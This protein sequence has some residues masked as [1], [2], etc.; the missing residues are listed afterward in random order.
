ML[1]ICNGMARSGSTYQ[2][3]LAKLFI[4]GAGTGRAHAYIAPEAADTPLSVAD[5]RFARWVRS[6]V[7]HV[8]KTHRMH[9]LVPQMVTEGRVRLLYIHRDIRDVAVS[10]K[11]VWG[12][13]GDDLVQSLDKLIRVYEDVREIRELAPE[14]VLWQ[15]YGDLMDEPEAVA[16]E[17]RR[18]LGIRISEAD[19][20]DIVDECSLGAVKE[21]CGVVE[22]DLRRRVDQLRK[23]DPR[24]AAVFLQ[25]IGRGH[26]NASVVWH[27]TE[28]LLLY[29]HISKDD[30]ATGVW[31][32]VLPTKEAKLLTERYTNWLTDAGYEV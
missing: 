32:H 4:E 31:K 27:D 22:R 1:I 9:P 8:V 20:R 17:I 16:E 29:N 21:R 3:N 10:Q 24:K 30:G 14:Y 7:W 19:Y 18:F 26:G 5:E 2:Y 12:M 15:R 23:Q 13:H 25:A 6:D 28:R 11:R